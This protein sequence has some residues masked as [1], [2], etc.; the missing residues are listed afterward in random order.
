[1]R[2]VLF[3]AEQAVRLQFDGKHRFDMAGGAF[4]VRMRAKQGVPRV[5]GVI[6]SSLRPAGRSM[7]GVAGF[8]EVP[9]MIVVFLVTGEAA[10]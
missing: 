5:D 7:T 6:E 1:M 8:A 2:L 4:G 9:F 10:R 3:V